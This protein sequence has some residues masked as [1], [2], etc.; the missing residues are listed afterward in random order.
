MNTDKLRA[1]LER[2]C[3]STEAMLHQDENI[4]ES[5]G[6]AMG[7]VLKALANDIEPMLA[8]AAK[9]DRLANTEKVTE[10]RAAL[11]FLNSVQIAL[12]SCPT[13][14]HAEQEAIARRLC[15]INRV[16]VSAQLGLIGPAQVPELLRTALGDAGAKIVKIIAEG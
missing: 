3:N 15:D 7:E 4:I 13:K 8:L 2:V 11:C 12:A 9:I 14:E 5:I 16:L 10:M 6:M 1:E